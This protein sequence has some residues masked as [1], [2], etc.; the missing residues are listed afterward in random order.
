[1]KIFIASYH[2]MDTKLIYFKYTEVQCIINVQKNKAVQME[3]NDKISTIYHK[4]L[5]GYKTGVSKF[6]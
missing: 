3:I 6:K 1:M 2:V 5:C 4:E